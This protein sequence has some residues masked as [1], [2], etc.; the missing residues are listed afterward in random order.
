MTD[1]TRVPR[2]DFT[3]SQ[4]RE[5][6]QRVHQL[7]KV[8]TKVIEACGTDDPQLKKDALDIALADLPL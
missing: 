7:E 3:D 6:R 2:Y 4:I 1:M 8:I 5:L